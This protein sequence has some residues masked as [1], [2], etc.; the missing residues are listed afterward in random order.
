MALVPVI[1]YGQFTSK[2]VTFLSGIAD[3]TYT[4]G[5]LIIG[6]SSTG[7]VSFNTLTAGANVTITN[8]NGTITIASSGSGGGS[9][10]VTSVSVVSANGFAGTVANSTSTP[11]ITL[12]TSITGLLKGDGTAISA[13]SAG[14]DYVT[15]SST[16]TFT[17]KTYDTAGTGNSFSV[18]GNAI[19]GFVGNGNS[20]ALSS[21]P[22]FAGT[23][24]APAIKGGTGASSQVTI[25]ST[26]G[27]GT[28]DM[29]TF[30]TGSQV[31]AL[32]IDTNQGATFSSLTNGI[33]KSTSGK[34][35]NATAGTDYLTPTGSGASLTGIPTSVSNSDG[36]LTISPTTG[37]VVASLAL[38]HANTWT[39]AQTFGAGKILATS[40]FITTGISDANG[41]TILGFSPTNPAGNF[42]QIGNGVDGASGGPPPNPSLTTAGTDTDI[43]W[44]IN[45]KGAGNIILRAS[46]TGKIGIANSSPSALLTIG[47]AGT[48][49]GTFSMAGGSSGTVTFA[50]P[51]ASGTNTL[52]F[53]A[54]TDTIV[55][56]AT[57]DT[58]TNKTINLTSN[59]LVATSAQLAAAVTDET[60]T[61][62]LVFA[63]S[64]TLTTASLGSSTA[65]TQAPGDGSTK[66]ATTAYVDAA[67][68]GT[69]FKEA[70]K[71]ATTTALPSLIYANGSSGVGATLT[72]VGFG[73]VSIDGSTPSIGDRLLVKNQATTFQNGIYTVT[74][75]GTVSTVFVLT[76][77]TD[78]D[79]GTDIDAGDAVFVTAGTANTSTTWAYN[80]VSNPTMGTTAI[81]FAQI[82][83]PGSITGG[84]G[85]TVTGLSIAIDTSV[86]V[87][88]TT[89]QTLSNKTLT[90]P[91]FTS[92]AL[93]TP[94]SGVA[95][96]LTGTAAG[97]TAGNVT[98]NA[99]LTGVITSVGNATSIASQTGTGTKFVVD[100][101]PTLVT[102]TIG[103][104]TA[105]SVN[106]VTI[107]APA[108][109]ATL[110]LIT[111][112]S[113][114][115]A[116]AFAL[117]LTSTA[118]TNATFPAGTNT[119]YSTLAN[120]ITS[121]QMLSSVS[122][123]TGTGSLVFATSPTLI[124]P[125][126][127]TPTSGTLTNTTGFPVANLAGAGTGVLTFLATPSSANLAAAVTNE[128]GSGL[129]VFGTSPTLT[130]P[131]ISSITNTGTLTL[132]TST[133]TLIGRATTDTLT[134]KRV[135]RRTTVVTQAAAPVIDSDNMDVVAIT[136]LAQAITSMTTNL[137]GTPVQN[138][139][140]EIQITDNATA[141]AITWGASFSNGGLVNLPLTTVIS[142]KL[143][144]LLEWDATTKWTCVA[145]A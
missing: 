43:T 49:A 1:Q 5:Q 128:T 18:N 75:V 54:A 137:T 130:T 9:G 121:A 134:N 93:G 46:G 102:P 112:S 103:V 117:T 33:V 32:V 38:G 87:D 76:R 119:L 59:T 64:P 13:A 40:P 37:A 120:S 24:T 90:S 68:Q 106:K 66:V 139:F 41:S 88:E 126:L 111:G 26:S 28:S 55:G 15:A 107:T 19:T 109:S 35:S 136:G 108:T 98:T 135:T 8:G 62:A 36:T 70:T 2:E 132:P 138:D 96:N 105:T 61:G 65:T 16:N 118:A 113:L 115:T 23:V 39:G 48:T 69:D 72:G 29:I 114:I 56:Q 50:V 57:T 47:T 125:I 145:V 92:P 79:Q 34:L 14:T 31:T 11:A 30:K 122:D 80:G 123:E 141:R 124:T 7:G 89:A 71:Y 27:V 22:I 60:G 91:I 133:D 21:N 73:A 144:V 12:T 110:T 53:P 143:R 100:T 99:N 42:I 140:L 129:L 6:N 45:A 20:V 3:H 85:I 51:S 82:S 101:S 95:T 81:T 10:T 4:D 58:L 116:G 83:G 77:S 104:A 25:E 97:L 78:F 127:G 84:N 94:A 142:T 131:V 63:T 17:N 86:T 74:V 44:N 67:I 52:T